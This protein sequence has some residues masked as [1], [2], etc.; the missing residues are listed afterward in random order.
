M[1][2]TSLLGLLKEFRGQNLQNFIPSALAYA[3][4][5]RPNVENRTSVIHW[6]Q[7]LTVLYVYYGWSSIGGIRLVWLEAN[8][9][10]FY[11]SIFHLLM[12][13]HTAPF[14]SKDFVVFLRSAGDWEKTCSLKEA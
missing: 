13:I 7:E 3:F 11:V 2:S 8:S 9:K 5:R 12:Y 4:G 1:H 10:P 6:C 14:N